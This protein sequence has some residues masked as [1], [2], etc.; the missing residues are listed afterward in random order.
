MVLATGRR[1]TVLIWVRLTL[2]NWVL[3]F[4]LFYDF[5][6]VTIE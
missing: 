3:G 5:L 2:S 4:E 6:E 1:E